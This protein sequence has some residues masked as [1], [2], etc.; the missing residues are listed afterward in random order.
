[1]GT[2]KAVVHIE[3]KVGP[4][5]GPYWCLTLECGH[6]AFRRSE[7]LDP[8]RLIARL[9]RPALAAPTRVRCIHCDHFDPIL[10]TL[11]PNAE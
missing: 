7:T 10:A 4:R 3:H 1:M 6:L 8:Q 11:D 2:W 9:R 5:G